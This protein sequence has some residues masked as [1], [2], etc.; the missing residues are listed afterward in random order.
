MQVIRVLYDVVCQLLEQVKM[1]RCL[2]DH[3]IVYR[4]GI[5]EG[6]YK[7][8]RNC[9]IIFSIVCELVTLK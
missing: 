7:K 4:D 6:Q 9:V 3:V 2:P 8:V 5:S 1:N